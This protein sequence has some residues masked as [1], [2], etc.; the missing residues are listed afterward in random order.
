MCFLWRHEMQNSTALG[1]MNLSGTETSEPLGSSIHTY[2]VL[3]PC[4]KQNNKI[5]QWHLKHSDILF[6]PSPV[7]T[8]QTHTGEGSVFSC[9]SQQMYQH[10]EFQLPQCETG[11]ASQI[12]TFWGFKR[13]ETAETLKQILKSRCHDCPRLTYVGMLGGGYCYVSGRNR[14]HLTPT[15]PALPGILHIPLSAWQGL[16]LHP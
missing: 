5:T 1:N 3:T 4:I 7:T 8:H 16:C 11:P 13:G 12:L 2:Q 14:T 15:P 10:T 9:S 6:H